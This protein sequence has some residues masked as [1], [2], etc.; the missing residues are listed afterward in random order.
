M[1]KRD[2][3]FGNELEK[4]IQLNI[5][6]KTNILNYLLA[7]AVCMTNIKVVQLLMQKGAN[8]KIIDAQGNTLLHLAARNNQPKQIQVSIIELIKILIN[9]GVDKQAKNKEGHTIFS[10]A[11][12]ANQLYIIDFL[13]LNSRSD[14][15][16]SIR[17]NLSDGRKRYIVDQSI[18]ESD[19]RKTEKGKH[20]AL[21]SV[22]MPELIRV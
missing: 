11:I 18:I 8:P 19:L 3:L 22:N 15:A 9:E 1:Q 12:Q 14:A 17:V 4:F 10:Q 7:Q 20:S 16:K 5:S 2:N 6:N 21:N 13:S